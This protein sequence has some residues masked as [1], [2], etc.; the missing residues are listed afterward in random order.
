MA[1]RWSGI[2]IDCH[3]VERVAAFWVALLD[4]APGATRPGWVYLGHPGDVLP[5]LV[6]Q[7]VPELKAVKNRLHLDVEVD[8]MAAS[9]A[10]VIELGGSETDERHHYDEGVVVVMR[11]VE[12]NEFCLVQRSKPV[13]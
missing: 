4:R 6:F 13:A 7:A 9:I 1:N 5:R 3:D 11:D 8:D 10:Q 12:D 2:T